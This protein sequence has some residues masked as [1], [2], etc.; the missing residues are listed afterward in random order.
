MVAAIVLLPPYSKIITSFGG[1][2]DCVPAAE[3]F[4]NDKG[5]TINANGSDSVRAN[6]HVCESG[7]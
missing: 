7:E 4:D 5:R 2:D 1:G 3:Q 6:Q